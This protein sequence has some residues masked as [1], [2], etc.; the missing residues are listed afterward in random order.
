[1]PPDVALPDPA[2]IAAR[3]ELDRLWARGRKF[4][5][6]RYAIMG[7][8]MTW[9]SERRLVAAIS[10]A[11]GIGVI[12]CGSMNPDQLAEEIAGAQS[13]TDRPFGVNPITMH[14]ALDALI[15]VCHE[16]RVGHVVLAGGIPPRGAVQAVKE[17]G[18]RLVCFAPSLG[19]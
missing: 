9:V 1:M 4:L 2:L 7:G 6:S 12:A 3:A 8:A 5:G 19:L 13:L 16:A 14:P 10:N 17:G 15:R 11:G 18:A